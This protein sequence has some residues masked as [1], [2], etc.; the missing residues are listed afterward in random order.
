MIFGACLW[1]SVTYLIPPDQ[2]EIERAKLD[3]TETFVG[4]LQ[5]PCERD[6]AKIFLRSEDVSFLRADGHYTQVYTEKER[7]FC[8]WPVTEAKKRLLPIGF[9]QTHRSYLVNPAHVSRFE[10]RK[11]KGRCIF[12]GAD[13]PW[14]PVSRSNLKVVQNA[15]ASQPSAVRA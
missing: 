15:L 14:V 13:L 9:L 5:I 6:G 10:R 12:G 1:V 2:I 8:A 11:D 3:K 7:L 4:G